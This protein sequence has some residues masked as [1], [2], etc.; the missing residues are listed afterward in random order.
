MLIPVMIMFFTK[1]K[2]LQNLALTKLIPGI[3]YYGHVWFQ[4]VLGLNFSPKTKL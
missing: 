3:L 4:L 2:S 1:R